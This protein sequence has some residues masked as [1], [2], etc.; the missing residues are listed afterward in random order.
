MKAKVDKYFSDPNI[1][2]ILLLRMLH[3]SVKLLG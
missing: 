1:T 2:I 3:E